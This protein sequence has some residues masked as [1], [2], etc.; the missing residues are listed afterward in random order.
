MR[1]GRCHWLIGKGGEDRDENAR[2][3]DDCFARALELNPELPLAH[4]IRALFD[5]DQGRA[6]DAALALVARARDGA[7]HAEL[8]A[9]LVQACR[10]CGLLEASVAAHHH[11]RR[12]DRAVPTS[13]DHTYW[14]LA[15]FDRILEHTASRY[16]GQA[17]V[18]NRTMH[19]VVL[20]ERGDVEQAARELR[21]VEAGRLTTYMRAQ[22]SAWRALFEGRREECLEGAESVI[23]RFPDPETVAWH[24]RLVAH[25]GKPERA[26]RALELALDHG[27]NLVAMLTRRDPLL[28]PVRDAPKFTELLERARRSRQDARTSFREAG[29]EALLG[30]RTH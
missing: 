21:E 20:G 30:I 2:R 26:L 9:A 23:Q 15:D 28:D 17:S 22:V 14:Q 16:H 24:A 8:Y 25:C 3:A 12:L 11:A 19:A 10:F 5:I 1:L 29:G 6:L 13:V 27:F 4:G 18:T 7:A